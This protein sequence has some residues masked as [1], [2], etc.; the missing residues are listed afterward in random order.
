MW[1][2]DIHCITLWQQLY[3][4][5]VVNISDHKL[6]FLK[7]ST[8]DFFLTRFSN[9]PSNEE[10]PLF[11]AAQ[12]D[13]L[14]ARGVRGSGGG[15]GACPATIT[16]EPGTTSHQHEHTLGRDPAHPDYKSMPS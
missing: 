7:I 12:W 9:T 5:P 10:S 6:L 14:P 3:F 16:K 13:G 11:S 4:L 15:T 1:Q 2:S 8:T